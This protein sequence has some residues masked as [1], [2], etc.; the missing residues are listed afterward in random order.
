[1]S[2]EKAFALSRKFTY[3]MGR[4][5]KGTFPSW[6]PL[7]G[8]KGWSLWVFTTFASIILLTVVYDCLFA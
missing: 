7:L 8:G 2:W 4:D 1:M 3:F 6:V 5:I